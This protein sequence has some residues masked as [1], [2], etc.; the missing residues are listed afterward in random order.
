MNIKR[1]LFAVMVVAA[2]VATS[3]CAV[4]RATASVDKGA[5]L[6]SLKRMHVVKVKED[7]RGVEK[8]IATRLGEMG[9][10]ATTGPE[11]RTD[12]DANVTYIDKWYWDITMYMIELTIAVR[13]P[14]SDFPLAT[15]NSLHTSLTR[16]SPK[17][18]VEEV[19]ANI[20]K[21][22]KK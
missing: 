6:G 11:K 16:K 4:N 9:F 14:K 15:G 8:L 18:M 10:V 17:E 2:S 13:D 19:T 20:F 3:G 5:D 22:V 7:E 1:L 12:V 21:D